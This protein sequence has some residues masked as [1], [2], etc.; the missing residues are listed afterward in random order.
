MKSA[1]SELALP[2]PPAGACRECGLEC[3]VTALLTWLTRCSQMQGLGPVVQD[4]H[5]KVI[6]TP[7]GKQCKGQVACACGGGGVL[8]VLAVRLLA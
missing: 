3:G 5:V 2:L 1:A 7:T 8:A 4:K 6:T